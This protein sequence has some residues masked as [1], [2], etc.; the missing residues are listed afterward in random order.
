MTAKVA[1][2]LAAVAVA[3][4][5]GYEGIKA[6]QDPPRRQAGREGHPS[7]RPAGDEAGPPSARV[8]PSARRPRRWSRREARAPRAGAG[9]DAGAG[10]QRH[11]AR[12]DEDG[13]QGAP[14]RK[15]SPGPEPKPQRSEAEARSTEGE[16]RAESQG[17]AHR[18]PIAQDQSRLTHTPA[19]EPSQV[20]SATRPAVAGNAA[21]KAKP[22]PRCRILSARQARAARRRRRSDP[23]PQ[24]R[25][26]DRDGR[27]R[28]MTPT[29]TQKSTARRRGRP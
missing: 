1:I 6:V 10:S 11:R 28:A 25:E 12:P 18:G 9:G 14:D 8:A 29:T 15:P 5:A 7:A 21:P 16:G 26:A 23:A 2:G 3:G 13:G 19:V 22:E 20:K 24:L 27:D 17:P 4:G